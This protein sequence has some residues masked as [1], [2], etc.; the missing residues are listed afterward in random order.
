MNT[1]NIDYKVFHS[2]ETFRTQVL[3]HSMEEARK[4]F[5]DWLGEHYSIN[6]SKSNYSLYSIPWHDE[7]AMIATGELNERSAM[8]FKANW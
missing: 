5:K 8:L 7:K 6:I 4:T 3:G 1:Y 2:S